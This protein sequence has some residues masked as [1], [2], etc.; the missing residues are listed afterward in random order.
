MTHETPDTDSPI[1]TDSNLSWKAKGLFA[2]LSLY[3]K[4]SPLSREILANA[5]RDGHTALQSAIAELKAKGYLR[6]CPC[7]DPLTKRITGWTYELYPYP[8]RRTGK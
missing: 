3:P 4:D 5:S 8:K 2:F 1:I 6:I 7:R